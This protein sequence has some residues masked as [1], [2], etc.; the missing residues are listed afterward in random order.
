MQE[1]SGVYTSPFLYTDGFRETAPRTQLPFGNSW[2]RRAL[3]I[4]KTKIRL[5]L[6]SRIQCYI[7]RKEKLVG[8]MK[9]HNTQRK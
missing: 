3:S 8:S 2:E 5:S 9:G 7:I 6:V 1:V 4:A